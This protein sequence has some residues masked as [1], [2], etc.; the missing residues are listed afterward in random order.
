VVKIRVVVVVKIRV[1]FF[2]GG[3][4]LVWGIVVSWWVVAG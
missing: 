3:C 4:V 1:V 2:G